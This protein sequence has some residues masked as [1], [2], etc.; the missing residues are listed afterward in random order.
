VTSLATGYTS[1]T[2][3][4]D[5]SIARNGKA[6]I[7]AAI[8]ITCFTITRKTLASLLQTLKALFALGIDHTGTPDGPTAYV[9][10]GVSQD[11]REASPHTKAT[12]LSASAQAM[13]P[14]TL[15]VRS[16][17][18]IIGVPVATWTWCHRSNSLCTPKI[19]K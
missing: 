17:L 19:V 11:T 6:A 4:Q 5:P 14:V 3:L 7:N 16:Y 1:L 12:L 9:R 18:T 2:Y 13:A 10:N 8:G 15:V